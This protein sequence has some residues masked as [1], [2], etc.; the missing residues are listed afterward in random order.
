[1]ATDI[2]HPTGK[3]FTD[4]RI[5]EDVL[6]DIGS[7]VFLPGVIDPDVGD[8]FHVD[9]IVVGIGPVG[10]L[11]LLLRFLHAVEGTEVH[12]AKVAVNGIGLEFP[13]PA[14]GALEY[15]VLVVI[16]VFRIYVA[17]VFEPV[18]STVHLLAVDI[19]GGKVGVYVGLVVVVIIVV[20]V[21]IVIIIDA[22]RR[23]VEAIVP[24]VRGGV[25]RLLLAVIVPF[26]GVSV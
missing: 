20:V 3:D 26:E 18:L 2:E 12:P 5:G 15:V 10:F 19:D 6:L 14:H 17:E 13:A 1:M 22:V 8:G 16:L 4:E 11:V 25:V 23:G 21:L 9:S 7:G 24:A